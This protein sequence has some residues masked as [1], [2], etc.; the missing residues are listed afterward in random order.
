MT[1]FYTR[2]V[3]VCVCVCIHV[4]DIMKDP[5]VLFILLS[6]TFFPIHGTAVYFPTQGA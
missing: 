1:L 6:A 3:C 4:Y 5:F 2:Y